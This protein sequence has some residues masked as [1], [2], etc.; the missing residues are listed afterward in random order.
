M[1][2]RYHVRHVRGEQ[3]CRS[4][5]IQMAEDY[6]VFRLSLGGNRA[7]LSGLGCGLRGL[8]WRRQ[9]KTEILTLTGTGNST[10]RVQDY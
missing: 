5:N 7:A 2:T 4:K 6:L 3:K 9:L 8:S 1:T 10:Q